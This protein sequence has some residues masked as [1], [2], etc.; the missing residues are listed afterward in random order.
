LTPEKAQRLGA[1]SAVVVVLLVGAWVRLRPPP[2]HG[3]LTV[4][5]R[6]PLWKEGVYHFE[7]GF[8]E[9]SRPCS[10]DMA[11][12]SHASLGPSQCPFTRQLRERR[13]GDLTSIIGF[14]LGESPSVLKLRITHDQTLI[15]DTQITPKY[16]DSHIESG[17]FCGRSAWASPPCASGSPFCKPF[18][19][20]CTAAADCPAGKVC[21]ISSA[22]GL[23]HGSF[24]ASQCTSQRECDGRIDTLN[25]CRD[26]AEC[27]TDRECRA[28]KEGANFRPEL[29][30]CELRHKNAQVV[31]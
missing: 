30:T 4:E 20:S 8:E 28:S 23:E 1:V 3:A 10:F 12:G 24:A 19:A 31:P 15:Y 14:T 22:W 2:C 26:D 5:L 25:A 9:G 18:V 7:L 27:S 17:T 16:E 11:L 6:P 29:R 21:C 13:F